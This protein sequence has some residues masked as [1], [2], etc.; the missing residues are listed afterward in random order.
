MQS[1]LSQSWKSEQE[2]NRKSLL[3]YVPEK[4]IHQRMSKTLI[5]FQHR[6]RNILNFIKVNTG[7]DIWKCA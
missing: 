4:R 6:V 1:L 2:L 7:V 3:S 5:N